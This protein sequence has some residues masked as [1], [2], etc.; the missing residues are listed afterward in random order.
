MSL[1]AIPVEALSLSRYV[2]RFEE[3]D[4]TQAAIVEARARIWAS[5]RRS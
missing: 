2:S 3:I 4:H 5:C 1:A